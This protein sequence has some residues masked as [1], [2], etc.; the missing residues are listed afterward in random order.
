M[1]DTKVETEAIKPAVPSS[2]HLPHD[3]AS[4]FIPP[5]VAPLAPKPAAAPAK[6]ETAEA[7]AARL[8]AEAAKIDADAEIEARRLNV[9]ARYDMTG[10]RAMVGNE[11][12]CAD[13][14]AHAALR[15]LAICL[16]ATGGGEAAVGLSRTSG[17]NP[18][19]AR[20]EAYRDALS[21]LS[22]KHPVKAA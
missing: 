14:S 22:A 19:P 16:L 9:I 1:D 6:P 2:D 21:Y 5:P 12:F 7:K 15:N 11:V 10:E 3:P 18:G 8:A 20:G 17:K 4:A 13:P